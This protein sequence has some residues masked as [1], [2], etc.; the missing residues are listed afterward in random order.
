MESM[1]ERRDTVV[2]QRI[3]LRT[4][5]SSQGTFEPTEVVGEDPVSDSQDARDGSK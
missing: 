5:G 3:P 1:N 2:A 4:K